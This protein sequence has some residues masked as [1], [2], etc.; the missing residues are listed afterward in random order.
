[1][2]KHAV[3]AGTFDPPTNGHLWV[4][5]EASKMFD[6]VTV[7]VAVNPDKNPVFSVEERVLMISDMLGDK[8]R[9]NVIAQSFHSNFLI[10]FA[11]D[12][13]ATH[14]VRGIRNIKDFEYE[15]VMSDVNRRIDPKITTTFLIPPMELRNVSSSLIRSLVGPFG[16]E[17]IVVHYVPNVVLTKLQSL[18][19]KNERHSDDDRL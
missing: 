17:S 2:K 16:W 8:T 6:I 15:K 14:L 1:M 3:Y 4:I 19:T 10:K 12:N 5:E 7:A 9:N 18:A 13:K 11:I